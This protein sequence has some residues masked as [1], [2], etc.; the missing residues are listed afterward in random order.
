[1]LTVL[2]FCGYHTCS[3]CNAQAQYTGWLNGFDA[4][5]KKFDSSRDRNRPFSFRAGVG[6]VCVVK[7]NMSY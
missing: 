7:Y 3:L 1:M 4:A 2:L 5:G 6:E